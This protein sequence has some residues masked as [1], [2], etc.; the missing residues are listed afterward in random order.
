MLVRFRLRGGFERTREEVG[1]GGGDDLRLSGRF[2]FFISIKSFAVF[3]G[4]RVEKDMRFRQAFG[5]QA[6]QG[7]VDD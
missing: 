6:V 5:E 2:L 7:R 1:D 3:V 4:V